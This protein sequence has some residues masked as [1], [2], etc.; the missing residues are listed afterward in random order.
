M[1]K[2]A[3]GLVLRAGTGRFIHGVPRRDLTAEDL[4]RLVY[5][6]AGRLRPGD[7]GFAEALAKRRESLIRSGLYQEPTGAPAEPVT[8]AP[9]Q[10]ETAT[11]P[12]GEGAGDGAPENDPT[13]SHDETAAPA[14]E[15]S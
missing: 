9:D 6:D 14:A 12:A 10:A 15:E 11:A 8:T 2:K 13:Q 3:A 1:S 5:R 7:A 4:E